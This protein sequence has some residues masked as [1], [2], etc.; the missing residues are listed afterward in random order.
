MTLRMFLVRHGQTPWNVHGLV[1][2]FSDG[3]GNELN[4]TGLEQARLLAVA[5]RAE[6]VAAVYASTLRRAIQTAEAV[7]REHGLLVQTDPDLRELNQGLLEGNNRT[8]LEQHYPDILKQWM[9]RP[10]S[11]CLPEG[12]GLEQLQTRAWGAIQ[13][14]VERHAEGSV[15]VVAHNLANHTILCKIAGRH[16]DEFRHIKQ[17]SACLNV[18]EWREDGPELV[19]ANDTRHLKVE[20][21]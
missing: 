1:Q 4:E 11:V 9:A 8:F 19:L 2:G 6:K 12:E 3:E 18:I 5:L 21:G 17:D 20:A 13:R 15:V 16:L 7:A 14:I 10:A